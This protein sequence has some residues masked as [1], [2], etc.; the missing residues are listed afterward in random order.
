MNDSLFPWKKNIGERA[1]PFC[2][3]SCDLEK[4]KK[5]KELLVEGEM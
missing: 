3:G 4:L 1:L 2:I 5:K